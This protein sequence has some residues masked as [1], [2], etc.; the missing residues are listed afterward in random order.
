MA[1]TTS[2]I[3]SEIID[4]VVARSDLA[5]VIQRYTQLKKTGKN[6]TGLCPFHAEK[7]PSFTV[8]TDKQMYHCFGCGESGNAINFLTKFAKIPFY[9]AVSQLAQEVGI[10]ISST[11]LEKNQALSKTKNL[12]QTLKHAQDFFAR[13][14][15][16]SQ[17]GIEGRKYLNSRGLE[18]SALDIFGVGYAPNAWDGLK[19]YLKEKKVDDSCA[20]EAGL[21]AEKQQTGHLYD[22]FRHR[23]T[24]PI[25][26]A[27]GR[28]VGFGGRTLG[29]EKPKYLNSP[30]SP[31]FH[32]NKCLYGL[33]EAQS[34]SKENYFILVEGYLDV[35][36]LSQFGI[37][38]AIATLGTA[39][40]EEHLG[41]LFK[42]R[43][44]IIFCFDGDTAGHQAAWRATMRILPLLT[45]GRLVKFVFLPEKEDPDSFIR[46]HGTHVF[47]LKIKNADSLTDY[48]FNSIF[49]A[50]KIE[51]NTELTIEQKGSI[52]HQAKPYIQK[53]PAGFY[54][55]MMVQKL[56]EI[57]KL[58]EYTVEQGLAG[59][60]LKPV[61]NR[62]STYAEPQLEHYYPAPQEN[63]PFAS[64]NNLFKPEA[65]K[66]FNTTKQAR[67]NPYLPQSGITH[68]PSQGFSLED[69]IIRILY[70]SAE[71]ANHLKN[72][73]FLNQSDQP[74]AKLLFKCLSFLSQ[75]TDKN[76]SYLHGYL[77]GDSLGTYFDNLVNKGEFVLSKEEEKKELQNAYNH[78]RVRFC[79]QELDKEL[80]KQPP[81]VKRM[82]E[83]MRTQNELKTH[84]I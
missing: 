50:L 21:L 32:K 66:Y 11:D 38:E 67:P 82:M 20:S 8:S 37:N 61:T 70:R 31:V 22:R 84:L 58:D 9:E 40:S 56:S 76:L 28:I 7:T 47:Q 64:P 6:Y 17:Q 33:Y 10:Y 3:P 19:N 73:D 81:D 63:T 74:A 46:T 51:A 52:I 12:T 5:V 36:A 39:T 59:Q 42:L 4:E 60:T 49:T 26:D 34:R 53:I 1:F 77:H 29:E 80:K 68:L 83:L 62:F 69:R 45:E 27:R 72:Y 25:K 41:I 14:L 2:R 43:P 54:K 44:E 18:Q 15:K 13:N 55:K 57:I 35:I 75:N 30:E 24:F 16:N 71:L 65:Q 79:Q 78:L 48:F 23:I